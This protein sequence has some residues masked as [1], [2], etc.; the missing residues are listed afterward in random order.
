MAHWFRSAILLQL[1]RPADAL[2]DIQCAIDNGLERYKSKPE[3][4]GRLAKA[5]AREFAFVQICFYCNL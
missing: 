4:F 3:Y 2:V 1:N 5:N